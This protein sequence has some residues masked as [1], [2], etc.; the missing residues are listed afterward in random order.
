MVPPSHNEEPRLLG[1]LFSAMRLSFHDGQLTYMLRFIYSKKVQLVESKL[2]LVVNELD[3][4]FPNADSRR[5]ET[6][7]GRTLYCSL[8]YLFLI[9]KFTYPNSAPSTFFKI[10]SYCFIENV[11]V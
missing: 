9:T 11:L 2:S 4:K 1:R 7:R 10:H 5:F 8:S 3:V 6:A